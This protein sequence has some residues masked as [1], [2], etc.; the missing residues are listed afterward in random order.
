MIYYLE[1]KKMTFISCKMRKELGFI[2]IY[3]EILR[4]FS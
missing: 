1:L 2:V 3:V 4:C